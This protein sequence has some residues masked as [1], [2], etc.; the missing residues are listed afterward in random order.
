MKSHMS[1]VLSLYK[2]RHLAY[3]KFVINVGNLG[4]NFLCFLQKVAKLNQEIGKFL[5][6]GY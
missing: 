6:L 1:I 5:M 3:Q 4:D 2:K